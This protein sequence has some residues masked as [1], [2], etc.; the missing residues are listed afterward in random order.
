M[1]ATNP[2]MR[3]CLP[4]IGL[5]FAGLF[6]LAAVF[7]APAASAPRP[8]DRSTVSVLF[9]GDDG[10]HQPASR[11]QQL[12]APLYQMG[13]DIFYTDEAE[14]INLEHMRRFDAVVFYAN[15]MEMTPAQEQALLDYVAEGGGFV[16]L[17]CASGMFRNSEAYIALVGAAF[18]R[19]GVG[20]VR[21]E[22][23]EP[24]HPAILGTPEFESWDET[25]VHKHHNPDRTVLEVRRE[26]D[27]V[28]PWTWVRTHG[29][30][31]IFYTAWGHD[32]RT[33]SQPGFQQLV[34]RGIKWAAGDWA[35][36]VAPRSMPY[37]Y[38]D[39]VLPSLEYNSN[40]E[41][42][43]RLRPM[44]HPVD[45][46]TSMSRMVAPPGFEV[47]LFAAEPDIVKPIYMAWDERGRLW[48][49]ETMD[50]P[51][52]LR[53]EVGQGN[54][55]IT[56][57]EDTDGDGRADAF[58]VFAEN[59]SIPT[60]FAFANGGVVVVQAPYTFFLKDTDGDDRADVR[61]VLFEGWGT[62][63]T[64]AGPNN[65]RM[66][67]D[68]WI[69][70]VV[71]YSGFEGTVGGEAHRFPMGFFRFKPDG[72]RLE[73]MRMTNNNT[74]GFGFSEEGIPFA[75]TANNNPSVYMPIPNRYYEAVRGWTPVR[76]G[77]IA[78]DR[79]VHPV[80]TRTRQ[81]DWKGNY[82][83]GSGHAL[84]TARDFPEKYWN[85]IA[86]VAGPTVRTLGRF[87]IEPDG[88][89]YKA[90]NKWNMLASDDEWTI[91]ILAEVGP[92]G[93][94]WMID[95]YNYIPQH[96][97]GPFREGWEHGQNNAYVT[98]LRDR[99]R[100]RIYRIVHQD[101]EP[102]EPM[103]LSGAS[104]Q[105]LV[106]ALRH[107]N[108]FWRQTAQRLL[109]DRGE[110]DVAATLYD[111]VRDPSVDALGLNPA[112]V[113]ALWTLHGL[114]M[115]AGPDGEA[116]GVAAEAL[117][118]PSAA[119]RRAAAQVLP[120]SDA[121]R[122]ALMEHNMLEDEDARVRLAVLLALADTPPSDATG[123]AVF[124]MLTAP[125]NAEDAWIPHAAT[126]AGAQHARGF[127]RAANRAENLTGSVKEAVG[128]VAFHR[129]S[130]I[131]SGEITTMDMAGATA[132]EAGASRGGVR[133]NREGV[134]TVASV[135]DDMAFDTR[136]IEATAGELVT[137][138]FVN[139][140]TSPAMTHNVVVLEHWEY[141]NPVGMAALAAAEND[142]I[143]P[144]HE[145]KIIAW[146]PTAGPGETV[147]VTFTMPPPGDYPF[148]CT[149]GGHYVAMQG[150]LV[151]LD[152]EREQEGDN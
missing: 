92:D 57:L 19:H 149:Y 103:D 70:G 151:S 16:P 13:V 112:A 87:A 69:W 72:S 145:E 4:L 7:C 96:N 40:P 73:F 102:G 105:E 11:A 62:F 146:T 2:A 99:E 51:N 85:R 142:Y 66:G 113:H 44:Q 29:A 22:R 98:D 111:L 108:M 80:T 101:A 148:I 41:N 53:E 144:E 55:R 42:E 21:T 152:P 107:D 48:V 46:E 52:Q 1:S 34:A 128:H 88:S 131:L 93:A 110:Q 45:V 30:G 90:L 76:L 133:P 33:W 132:E 60:G 67:F 9:L 49:A 10:H 86:F 71:G 141:V 116:F 109:V 91:P 106:A 84:Y 118:H 115:L 32:Q 35:L 114:G 78:E 26:G 63:D 81:G 31:R 97:L 43:R 38:V 125:E 28:E 123:A 47:R 104:P 124:A 17:H 89:D 137:I 56:I 54:D 74:W 75:S 135:G 150:V 130:G 140:A 129:M 18:D 58:K 138:R 117:G 127:L 126:A 37:E 147:Q 68:N 139:N 23:T 27:H 119:V 39:A 120:P 143:P 5:Q 3:R 61:D 14:D 50:Y 8:D 20:V 36:D 15:Y 134:V 79:R 83:A 59:L 64:H 12:I 77:T 122:D 121:S 100:G 24:T 136:F 82:T 6:L 65:I 95:W 94:L 25:Y